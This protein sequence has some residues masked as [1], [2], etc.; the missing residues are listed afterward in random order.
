MSENVLRIGYLGEVTGI[1]QVSA[2]NRY[3]IPT[4]GGVICRLD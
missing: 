3:R 2:A 4:P 1:P